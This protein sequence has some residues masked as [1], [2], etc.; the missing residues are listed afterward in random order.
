MERQHL[1]VSEIE[2]VLNIEQDEKYIEI[3][4]ERLKNNMKTISCISHDQKRQR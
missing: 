2:N 4:N 1:P 3:I